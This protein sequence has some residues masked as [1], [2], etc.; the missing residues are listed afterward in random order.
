MD[1]RRGI[2]VWGLEEAKNF[3]RCPSTQ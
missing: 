1:C 2:G 3:P